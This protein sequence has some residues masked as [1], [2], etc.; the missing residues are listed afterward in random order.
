M[1]QIAD[2]G[3][4]EPELKSARRKTVKKPTFTSVQDFLTFLGEDVAI[5]HIPTRTIAIAAGIVLSPNILPS[6]IKAIPIN[7]SIIPIINNTFFILA[8]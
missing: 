7:A 3:N 1:V 4:T 8:N 5:K 2:G 6:I